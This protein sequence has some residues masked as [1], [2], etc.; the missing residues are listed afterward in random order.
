MV[1]ADVGLI[2]SV[3]ITIIYKFTTFLTKTG[4][5]GGR[6]KGGSTTLFFTWHGKELWY[7]LDKWV[8]GMG[9]P[10]V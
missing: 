3:Q 5:R 1:I 4:G 7:M 8:A 9:L 6:K 10:L 2:T